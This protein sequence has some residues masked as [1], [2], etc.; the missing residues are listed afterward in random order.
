MFSVSWQLGGPLSTTQ[1]VSVSLKMKL[2]AAPSAPV[3]TRVPE[4]SVTVLSVPFRTRVSSILNFELGDMPE[5]AQSELSGMKH[6][7]PLLRQKLPPV[8]QSAL[9]GTMFICALV[10]AASAGDTGAIRR[11]A[12]TT[13]RAVIG[14]L[15]LCK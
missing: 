1:T 6:V 8:K 3:V 9:A 11:A 5:A 15:P 14:D 2:S 13:G 10:A 7:A 4:L 12:S